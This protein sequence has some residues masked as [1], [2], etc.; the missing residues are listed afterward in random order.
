MSLENNQTQFDGKNMNTKKETQ[1]NII[2][3]EQSLLFKPIP[4]KQNTLNK[5]PNINIENNNF[6]NPPTPIHQ[7]SFQNQYINENN[8]INLIKFHEQ[9]N[10][11]YINNTLDLTKNFPNDK[12]CAF[13]F[14]NRNNSNTIN[15]IKTEPNNLP[16]SKVHCTCKKTKCIKKYCEC[17]SSGNK[18]FNCKCENCEN[19]PYYIENVSNKKKEEENE[20][21]IELNEDNEEKLIIC[22]CSKSGCNKNYCECF[23]AKVKCNNKCRCIKCLNKSEDDQQQ[24]EENKIIMRSKSTPINISSNNSSTINNNN[25]NIPENNNN[26]ITDIANNFTVHRISVV[27]NKAQTIINTEKLD[28]YDSHKFLNKKRNMK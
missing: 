18:C 9:E 24:I 23:K 16:N 2:N 25:N 1:I 28:L 14:F 7:N 20:E 15:N 6:P 4:I 5:N 8:K 10:P 11:Q 3:P 21:N 17:Y 12:A 13:S 27:I 26:N 19:K 22:T